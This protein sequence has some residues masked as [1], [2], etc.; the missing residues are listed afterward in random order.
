METTASAGKAEPMVNQQHQKPYQAT[1]AQTTSG[2]PLWANQKEDKNTTE[3]N[4]IHVHALPIRS[5][6]KCAAEISP[7]SHKTSLPE[8]PS[9][10]PA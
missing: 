2:N 8:M 6:M 3:Q 5:R 10:Y 9:R 4:M 7:E 1:R